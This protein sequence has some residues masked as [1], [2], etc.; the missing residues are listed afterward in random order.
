VS[1]LMDFVVKAS[2]EINI[3][4]G[5]EGG[6]MQRPRTWTLEQISLRCS[7]YWQSVLRFGL[8]ATVLYRGID[9]A[10]FRIITGKPRLLYPS[11]RA[12]AIMDISLMLLLSAIWWGL[13]RQIAASKRKNQ[14]PIPPLPGASKSHPDV[15]R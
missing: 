9:Y 2:L 14:G 8:P 11:W 7:S 15:G 6:V 12:V 5:F 1:P 13:M 10:A 4:I 3:Q